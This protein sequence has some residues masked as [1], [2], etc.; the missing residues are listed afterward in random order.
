MRILVPT[1]TV[2][3]MIVSYP[4]AY[5]PKTGNTKCFMSNCTRDGKMEATDCVR[6]KYL[7]ML[8]Q[9]VLLNTKDLNPGKILKSSLWTKQLFFYEQ[10]LVA[11]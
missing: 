3:L 2:I 7:H 6:N 4:C 1:A 8:V 5:R 9:C 11:R 10:S